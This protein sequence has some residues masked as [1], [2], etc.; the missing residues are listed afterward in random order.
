[1]P[2]RAT[3]P[4]AKTF[5]VVALGEAMVEFN[6]VH[7]GQPQY[8]QGFGGDTSNAAIAAARA[9][10]RVAYL[11]R[12]GQDSFG[13]ALTALWRAEG[14]DTRAVQS[15]S[16]HP[17]GIYFVSHGAAGH[18]FSYLRT[19]SAAS[20]MAPQ[21]LA[22]EPAAAL[23]AARILHLSGIS[24][25]ISPQACDTA[26]E[27]MRLAREAGTLVSFDSNLRLKLWPLARAQACIAQAV[28]LC[29]IFLP[30]LE[31]MQALTGLSD[32]D[33]IIDWGH[34]R[35]AA[36]VVLKLGAEGALASNGQ[37]RERVPGQ[38]VTPVDATGAGDCFCGNLLA[39]MAQGDDVFAAARYANAAAA[40]AVQGYGA[41]APLPYAR[42]VQAAVA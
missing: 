26:F 33:T 6:Q 41:V 37:R 21:W 16:E 24:L 8:L 4:G 25:A 42:Q 34:A 9:G 31:D 20:H 40:L 30:S 1:V 22:G 15:D 13:Q 29:D 2:E 7:P 38:R 17:T 35:G 23:Q 36:T 27:A 14:V 32:P 28:S 12:I 3:V 10:A 5:D 39:R 11:T 19:G 18:E